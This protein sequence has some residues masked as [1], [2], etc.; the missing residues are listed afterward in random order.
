MTTCL[1]AEAYAQGNSVTGTLQQPGFERWPDP[2][3]SARHSATSH[4]EESPRGRLFPHHSS[5]QLSG[6]PRVQLES[7]G[8]ALAASSV[9]LMRDTVT[10]SHTQLGLAAAAVLG[11]LLVTELRAQ[12]QVDSAFARFWAAK[13]TTGAVALV[14][15]VLRSRITFDE[16]YR[17]LQQ[18]RPYTDQPT[19]LV[20]LVNRTPDG[21]MHGF[22]V[23]IPPTYDPRKTYPARFQLHGG[24]GR[25]RPDRSTAITVASAFAQG[26]SDHIFIIP[27]AQRGAEWWRETQILNVRGIL[28][29]VKRLYNIDENRVSVSGVSDGATGAYYFAMRDTTPFASFLPLNG[30]ALVLANRQLGVDGAMFPSNLR[31]KPFFVVNGGRDPLYPSR[32]VDPYIKRFKA[33]GVEVDYRPQ[34]DAGHN[35]SW[36]PTMREPFEAFVRAHPRKPLP[37][38]LTWET[39]STDSSN[40]AHWLVI[41]GLGMTPGSAPTLD[42]LNT[43][44]PEPTDDFGVR[45]IGARITEIVKGSNADL[46][47][48]KAFDTLVELDGQTVRIASD[49]TEV[50]GAIKPGTE[51]ELLVARANLP[52][53]LKGVYDPMGIPP[54]PITLFPHDAPSGRVDLVRT[55]NTV[56]ALAKGVTAF[57]LLLSPDQ[58]DFLQPVKVIVNDRVVFEGRVKKSLTTLMK[59]SARDNDRTMLFGAELRVDLKK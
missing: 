1:P 13:S 2:E 40:R 12:E 28:D 19:E 25:P 36:W 24:V 21:V 3:G 4:N 39:S 41:D 55:G 20:E 34:P 35:L 6:L 42:D 44:Q 51:V 48:L 37:D 30:M 45:A 5:L 46:I 9:R 50:F 59:W 26:A 16:A 31:N 43:A 38:R 18:G 7:Q 32:K 14:D 53:E 29:R 49:L 57:T 27:Q 11:M 8:D 58:F 15:D 52:V 17:R 33:G 56:E 47:G 10:R 23:F 22:S 54:E